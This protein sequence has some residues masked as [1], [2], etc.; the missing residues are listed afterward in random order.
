MVDWEVACATLSAIAAVVALAISVVQI[1]MS[2]RQHL[3][4]RRLLLWTKTRGLMELCKS[5]RNFLEERD[6]GPEFSNKFIF[7]LLTNNSFLCDIGPAISHTLEQEWQLP[8]LS[9]L[10]EIRE[11]S[12]EAKMIFRRAPAEALSDFIS[13]YGALLWSMY[14]YQIMLGVLQETS[15][16][17]KIDLGHSIELIEESGQREALYESRTRLLSAMDRLTPKIVKKINSKCRL[18][19]LSYLLS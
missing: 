11:L 8:L 16:Q 15:E 19:L 7:L 6:D 1:R 18:T 17:L 10:E 12:F 2:N 3:F 4:A 13:S 14:Q 9:K 5:N